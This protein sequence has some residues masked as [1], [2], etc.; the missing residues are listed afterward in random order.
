MPSLEGPVGIL[1]PAP[2]D[3]YRQNAA[4]HILHTQRVQIECQ[5]GIRCPHKKSPVASCRL[6][7]ES[8]Y[9][10]PRWPGWNVILEF[11]VLIVKGFMASCCLPKGTYELQSISWIR[12]MGGREILY[13]GYVMEHDRVAP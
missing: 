11:G 3:P 1:S 12:G 9:S 2:G 7:Q 10:I 5:S 8:V 6:P 4:G 13:T